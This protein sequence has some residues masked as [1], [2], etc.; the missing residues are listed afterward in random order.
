MKI[1]LISLVLIAVAPAAFAQ[2]V[3][4]V[5]ESN[6]PQVV[7]AINLGNSEIEVNGKLE[8][9]S[10]TLYALRKAAIYRKGLI[11][12]SNLAV[13]DTRIEDL[14][15]GTVTVFG[16]D[17]DADIMTDTPL[18]R[19][20]IVLEILSGLDK[21]LIVNELP[22]LVPG[23]LKRIRVSA[24]L[25]EHLDNGRYALHIFS[26]GPEVLN[27]TMDGNYIAEQA[28]KTDD[29]MLQRQPDHSVSISRAVPPAVPVYPEDLKARNV[30]GSAKVRCT[31][32]AHGELVSVEV[33]EATDPLFGESLATAA[34][35]WKFE[36]AVKNHA[37]VP[38][39]AIIPYNFKL[40]P[41]AQA[42]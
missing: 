25:Q 14:T 40:P 28:K 37:Y 6:G 19:C 17:I 24:R 23:D 41:P 39:V 35:Q 27:T 22:D 38:A 26:D 5:A 20:F 18:K 10:G 34:R 13:K 12:F 4:I 7:R 36:P 3:L 31:I 2:N 15:K 42:K 1:R 11:T 33:T 9:S 32:D 30:T 8:N 21:G 16:T 29:F